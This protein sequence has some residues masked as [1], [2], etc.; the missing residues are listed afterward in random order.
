MQ[1]YE[2]TIDAKVKTNPFSTVSIDDFQVHIERS[3]D[4]AIILEQ[5]TISLYC[6]DPVNQQAIFVQT[7]PEADLWQAPFY[8]IAQYE[9]A[10]RLIAIPYTTLHAIARQVDINPQHIILLYS[11]GRCGSTLFSHI[12]NQNPNTVSFSEPD[13][14]TQLVMAHTSGESDDA[15]VTTLLYDTLMIMCANA[16]LHGF[17]TVAFKF[18]SYVLS[19]SDLLYQAVPEAKLIFLY[20]NALTWA[21]SFS[22]AFGSSDAELA[23]RLKHDG[24]DIIPSVAGYLQTHSDTLTWIEYLSHMWIST[25]QDSRALQQQGAALGYGRFEELKVAPQEVVQSLLAHCGLPMPTPDRLA[26]VLAKDS[27]AGTVGAQ[28]RAAPVRWLTDADLAELDRI[29]RE[30]DASLTPDTMLSIFSE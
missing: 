30:S 22:R 21:R 16:Q 12:L 1:A 7:P 4:P 18:R 26:E 23:E 27:Q 28:D 10:E 24:C 13:V 15:E 29:I 9:A 17:Q 25:M 14:F 2:L 5:P 20:R 11:T 19:V 8:F 3:V 6:L